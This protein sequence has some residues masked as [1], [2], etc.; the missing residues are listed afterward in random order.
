MRK[1]TDETGETILIT[2]AEIFNYSETAAPLIDVRI[3]GSKIAATGILTR[4]PEEEIIDARGRTLLPCLADHHL[5]LLALAAR[6]ESITC[7]PP[8]INNEAAL[9][10][11]LKQHNQG[12]NWFRGV[13]YHE[14]VAGLIDRHWLDQ[15]LSERPAR[16][17]HRGGR[18]WVINSK[19]LAILN[20]TSNKK[21]P[22]DLSWDSG[23]LYDSDAWLRQQLDSTPP[24]LSRTSREL[25]RLGIGLI[26]DM[27][28]QNDPFIVDF[29]NSQQQNNNLLQ[30]IL[31][32]GQPSLSKLDRRLHSDRLKIGPTKIHLQEANLPDFDNICELIT[33]SH[34]EGRS[35][36]FHCVTEIELVFALAV[37][38]KTKS[39]KGDRIEHASIVPHHLLQAISELEL[40]V[41]T[42]P[43]FILE[44]GDQYLKDINFEEI[45]YLYRCKGLLD[46][47]IRLAAGTDAPFG[48]ANPWLAMQAAVSR[49]S[50]GGQVINHAEALSPEEAV[51]L[52]LGELEDPAKLR[53]LE[54]GAPAHMCL[55][56]RNW[57]QARQALNGVEVMATW[58]AGQLIHD[59]VN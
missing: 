59:S 37:L 8:D 20:S 31:I 17:Q 25:A 10:H 55:L 53:H 12:D 50:S 16:I 9:A 24:D 26:T 7:G 15:H 19:G 33:E 3:T 34:V 41:V 39:I 56:D 38:S 14:S 44:R 51:S 49:C 54:A 43:N 23:H 22:S 46:Q 1:S 27:T 18:L 42:Q 47:E 2:N 30:D 57:H 35:V 13:S 21:S 45:P 48:T 40:I 11:L 36:A 4:Q 5:H 58:R 29:F 32:A 28:P 6:S 52:F